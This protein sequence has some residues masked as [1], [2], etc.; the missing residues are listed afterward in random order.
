MCLWVLLILA[1]QGFL[2]P[3]QAELSAQIF[4][5]FISGQKLSAETTKNAQKLFVKFLEQGTPESPKNYTICEAEAWLLSST[6]W[7]IQKNEAAI[8]VL[9]NYL[10]KKI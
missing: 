8:Q 9:Y 7:P 10:R 6:G 5:D 2:S 3:T 4:L 1:W